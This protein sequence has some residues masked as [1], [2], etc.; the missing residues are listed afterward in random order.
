[1]PEKDPSEQYCIIEQ[2]KMLMRCSEKKDIAEWNE[3][4]ENNKKVEIYLVGA[5]FNNVHLNWADFRGAH[6]DG[7]WFMDAHLNRAD[8][9]S[10]RLDEAEFVGA[11]LDGSN[12]YKAHLGGAEFWLAHLDGADFSAAHLAGA[13]FSNAHLDGAM[14]MHAHLD[15]ANFSDAHLVGADFFGTHLDGAD[16]WDACL[17]GAEFTNACV[18]GDTIITR[19]SIDEKTDFR[20]VGLDSMRIDAGIKEALK[21]NRR[22]MNWNEWIRAKW[23]CFYRWPAWVF[24][25]ISD[26]G[27]STMRIV[28]VFLF[29]SLLFTGVYLLGVGCNEPCEVCNGEQIGYIK[30]LVTDFDKI[31]DSWNWQLWLRAFYFSIVTMTTLGFGDMCAHE[32]STA[33]YII[34]IIQVL[35]GYLFLGALVTRLGV[36]FTASGPLARNGTMPDETRKEQKRRKVESGE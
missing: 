1:M 36:M 28:L 2:Y 8:F 24:W 23:K 34:L 26:Y 14:F 20:G 32:C 12:F 5:D 33:G 22:K 19:C 4:R 15:G 13:E 11:H 27:S 7:A 29:F 21:Y 10:A 31:N 18:N 6:L 25:F 35:L 3:W 9:D 30:N 17:D 16:F